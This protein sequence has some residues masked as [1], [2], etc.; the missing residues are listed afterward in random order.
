MKLFVALIAAVLFVSAASASPELD[1][2]YSF[3]RLS[4]VIVNAEAEPV[5]ADQVRTSL[6]ERFDRSL[7]YTMV[8]E[9]EGVIQTTFNGPAPTLGTPRHEALGPYRPLITKW[10]GDN[11]DGVVLVEI[12]KSEEPEQLFQLFAVLVLPS[13]GEVVNSLAV[14]VAQ[15]RQLSGFA[16]AAREVADQL[17]ASIPFDGSIIRR[18]GYRI[19]LNRGTPRL[20]LG[21]R[22]ATYTLEQQKGGLAFE[23]TGA[24]EITRVERNLAFGTVLVEKEGRVVAQG[25]KIRVNAPASYGHRLAMAG[26]AAARNP[27]SLFSSEESF[28]KGELGT[29]NVD[30]GASLVTLSL[31]SQNASATNSRTVFYPGAALR[32]ELWLTGRIF[33]DLGFQLSSATLTATGSGAS[34][35][36][37]SSVSDFRGLVGYRLLLTPRTAGPT[38]RFT[39]GYASHRFTID[40]AVDPMFF[41]SANYKGMSIGAGARLPLNDNWGIGADL[42]AMLFPSL[43]EGPLTSGAAITQLSAI[44]F[45]VKSYYNLTPELDLELKV[46]FQGYSAGFSGTGTRPIPLLSSS[47]SSRNISLG[48]SYY[49]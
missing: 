9:T 12:Q 30:F 44:D 22:L 43:D 28:E 45:M 33:V 5:Y 23:E 15:P 8:P 26:M 48:L 18:E 25:N 38:V 29:L 10:A 42:Y 36:L 32:G 34:E 7:R 20:S 14:P 41:G 24:I 37:N 47:R 35:R 3:E 13:T 4:V 40:P 19:V 1:K 49:F 2:R 11:I 31:A 16:A 39:L 17:S 6:N 21:Q 46:L 27:S